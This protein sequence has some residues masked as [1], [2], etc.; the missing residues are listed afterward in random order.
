M[1]AS[2]KLLWVI[3][4]HVIAFLILMTEVKA[5]SVTAD[6]Y[7]YG[8]VTTFDNQYEG[9]IRWDDEEIFWFDHFNASKTKN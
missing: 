1:I 5:Q 6:G 7:I 3:L 2:K 4:G 8:K 9:L